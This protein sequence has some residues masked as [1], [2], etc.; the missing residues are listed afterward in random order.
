VS[1]EQTV[2]TAGP[3]VLPSQTCSMENKLNSY[4][5]LISVYSS[6]V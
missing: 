3:V 2:F 6:W 4:F 1:I 5:C